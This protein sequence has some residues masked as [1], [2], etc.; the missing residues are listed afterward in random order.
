MPYKFTLVNSIMFLVKT[1]KDGETNSPFCHFALIVFKCN[2]PQA[3]LHKG[4][5]V[6]FTML[7]KLFS[8][9]W[10][11]DLEEQFNLEA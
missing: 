6:E 5:Y 7:K 8:R 11:I 1:R 3:Q 2:F 4:N 10:D 9:H